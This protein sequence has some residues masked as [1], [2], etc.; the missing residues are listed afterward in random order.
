M[1]EI[2]ILF[3]F[4]SFEQSGKKKEVSQILEL[5]NSRHTLNCLNSYFVC[6]Q[7][8]YFS[9]T[10]IHLKLQKFKPKTFIKFVNL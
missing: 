6:P 5:T 7:R 9:N 1:R 8:A 10:K 2:I 3:L 4:R